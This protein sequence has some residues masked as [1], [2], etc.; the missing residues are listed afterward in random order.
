[1]DFGAIIWIIIFIVGFGLVGAA[2]V[3][4]TQAQETL[5][6][7]VTEKIP[8]HDGYYLI[9]AQH[10]GKEEVFGVSDVWLLGIFDASD[11]YAYLKEGNTYTVTIGGYR[12]QL[13]SWY[14]NINIIH[15]E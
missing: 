11:R 5:T 8:Y 4:D 1:M 7:N 6:I 2:L 14:R 12:I 9:I 13:L 10:D 3:K 15:K